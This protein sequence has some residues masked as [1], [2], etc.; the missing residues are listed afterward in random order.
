MRIVGIFGA[1]VL[2][3][4]AWAGES[5]IKS[6]QDLLN[7]DYEAFATSGVVNDLF[8][9]QKENE[10]YICFLGDTV[11]KQAIRQKRALNF[12]EKNGTDD[13]FIVPNIPLVC[14]KAE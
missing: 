5:E 14:V 4:T 12:I 9:L 13:D 3:V 8:G 11:E 1:F 6:A 7:Q 10:V 2:T